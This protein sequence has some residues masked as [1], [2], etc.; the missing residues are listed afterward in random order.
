MKL[1]NHSHTSAVQ[2]LEMGKFRVWIWVWNA[3]VIPPHTLLGMLLLIH[4]W[5]KVNPR[6]QKYMLVKGG[7]GNMNVEGFGNSC[8][9]VI[10]QDK[11]SPFGHQYDRQLCTVHVFS[12]CKCLVDFPQSLQGYFIGTGLIIRLAQFHG[13]NHEEYGWIHYKH[14]NITKTTTNIHNKAR[15]IHMYIYIYITRFTVPAKCAWQ[16]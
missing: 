4:A 8:H 10:A 11:I 2:P 15:Q 12:E 5:I 3:Y 9:G 6:Y 13:S 1:L 16:N 14:N 7:P